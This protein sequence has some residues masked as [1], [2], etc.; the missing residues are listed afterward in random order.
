M[1][2]VPGQSGG[3]RCYDAVRIAKHF[4]I[5]ESNDAIPCVFDDRSSFGIYLRSVL[6]AITLDNDPGPVA[7]KINDEV[8]H[9]NLSSESSNK[10]VL[11]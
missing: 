1:G 8:A 5:P 6:A 7:S 9:R 4:M 3:N 2:V 10:K 11:A